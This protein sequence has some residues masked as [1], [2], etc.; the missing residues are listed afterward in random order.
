MAKVNLNQISIFSFSGNI[1][2]FSQKNIICGREFTTS[3]FTRKCLSRFNVSES[4]QSPANLAQSQVMALDV[5]PQLTLQLSIDLGQGCC[6][7]P[8]CFR[9]Q[10][11]LLG[12]WFTHLFLIWL[13]WCQG[14]FK[15][16]AVL[17]IL[18]FNCTKSD[19]FKYENLASSKS[20]LV[21]FSSRW[22][23]DFRQP[24]SSK[25]LAMISN[26]APHPSKVTS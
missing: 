14:N 21:N 8:S 3:E 11:T 2:R 5:S 23:K 1:Y 4:L 25:E 26:K 9:N 6:V 19:V 15:R 10:E 24:K 16:K 17:S 12:N 13:N 20:T 7:F 22:L 18:A